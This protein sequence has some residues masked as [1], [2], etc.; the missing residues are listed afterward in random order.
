[1]IITFW[2]RPDLWPI[3]DS[4]KLELSFLKIVS[5]GIINFRFW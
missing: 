4:H 2:N 5:V 1:L 3:P